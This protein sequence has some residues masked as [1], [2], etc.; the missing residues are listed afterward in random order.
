MQCSLHIL[1]S[2][3]KILKCLRFLSVNPLLLNV[4]TNIHTHFFLKT[5]EASQ[6]EYLSGW[7]KNLRLCL[8][9]LLFLFFFPP[10]ESAIYVSHPEVRFKGNL[11]V[12]KG[13]NNPPKSLLAIHPDSGHS[14]FLPFFQMCSIVVKRLL[15]YSK[16]GA[17]KAKT[18]K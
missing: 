5:S 16:R 6:L 9:V 18:V 10:K 8:F 4:L 2:N 7:L 13:K 1:S 12:G 15:N 11:L 3:T 17:N 14:I